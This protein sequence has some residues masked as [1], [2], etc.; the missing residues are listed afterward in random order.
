M[1]KIA[2][3]PTQIEPIFMIEKCSY[4]ERIHELPAKTGKR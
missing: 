2:P 1:L 4:H 3:I